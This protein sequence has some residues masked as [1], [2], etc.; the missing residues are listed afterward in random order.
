MKPIMNKVRLKLMM[1]LFSISS[2]HNMQA[3]DSKQDSRP[4]IIFIMS[5]DHARQAI[6]IYGHPIGKVAPTPNIDRIGREG[7]V[8][9][10]NYCCNSISGPSRAAIL[11]GKHSHKNGFMKNWAKGFDGSQQ[12]LPKILQNNGYE[13]AIIGKWHLVSKPTGFNH[14]L[15]LN[16]Q[17]D[18]YNPEFINENDTVRHPGY[19]TDLITKYCKEWMENGRDKS[20]PFF[21]M[22]HHKAVHRNWVPAERHYHLYEHTLFPMPDNYYDDYEGRYAAQ[23]QKMNVYKDMYEGHDLK[24]VTGIESDT[25]LFDP[26][27]HAFLGTMT[28]D[29]K[30]RFFDAYRDRNNEFYSRPRSFN[31]IA[32][33][34]Y[35]RYLQDYM[36][37]VASVDES[38]GEILEYLKQSGLEENTIV[39]YT[40]DQGFY[41]GEHGWFDKRF[42]YEESFGMPMVMKWKGHIKPNTEVCGLTQ[43]I[44]FAPTFLDMCGIEIPDDMQGLSFK[45]LV[46]TGETPA[47]WRN[48]L[49]Y[50]YYEFPGFH[51]VRA[52]YGIKTMRYKLMHFY[53][54]D[55][56]ELYD[57]DNDKEEMNNLYD[58]P[59]Y[60]IITKQLKESLDSLQIVYDVPEDLCR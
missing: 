44:D 56:W 31:E 32:E 8:F 49:Y 12:T 52:H 42:M 46:E 17:G 26:W 22:M 41:L 55:K 13:T 4:N 5:D 19:V 14:W 18:Y 20:K 23:L 24:M 29:E 57:L 30:K 25:L 28:D 9:N 11:T 15:I 2:F 16:D 51:S 40:T 33:W 21:L 6:S 27:P 7:A 38:V 36:G 35:Q 3:A 48:S 10:N 39:V 45:S 53:V 34:K 54:D 37:C 59:G 1:S 50:H 47:D 43:N 60:E 58:K